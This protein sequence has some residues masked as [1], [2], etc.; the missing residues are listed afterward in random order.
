MFKLDGAPHE[1]YGLKYTL[2]M[3]LRNIVIKLSPDPV[4]QLTILRR[5]GPHVGSEIIKKYY[6]IWIY[7]K[8]THYIFT[9]H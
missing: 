1:T 4:L 3:N 6:K 8:Q 5:P 2:L 9:N 7:N